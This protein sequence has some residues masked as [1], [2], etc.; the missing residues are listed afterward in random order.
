MARL[1]IGLG[2]ILVILGISAYFGTGRSSITA[3]IPAFLG[4]AFLLLGWI[5]LN[6]RAR[7]HAMH[8]AVLVALLGIIGSLMRPA[9]ALFSDAGLD[10]TTAVVMQLITAGLCLIFLVMA[11]RSFAHA[12]LGTTP[13]PP[14]RGM[15]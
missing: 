12:R 2:V 4:A 7:K 1:S 13:S 11:I 5:A 9:Q 6:E 15:G 14:G 10:F 8:G 3:L